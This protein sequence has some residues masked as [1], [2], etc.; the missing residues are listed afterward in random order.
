MAQI[1][2]NYPVLVIG[3]SGLDLISYSDQPVQQHVSNPA[4]IHASYGGVARNIAETLARLGQRANLI[5]VVGQDTIGK[6]LLDFTASAGVNTSACLIAPA[7]TATYLAVLDMDRKLQ[8]GLYDM[9]IIKQITIEYLDQH[10]ELFNQASLVFFDTNLQP[11]IIRHIFHLAHKAGIPVCADATSSDQAKRLKPYLG[12]LYLL[13]ANRFEAA[14]LCGR[15]TPIQSPE[16]GIETARCLINQGVSIAVLPMGEDGVCYA[17]SDTSGHIPAIRTPLL[18]P[19]GTGDALTATILFGLLNN[20]E[21]DEAVRLG[22]TAS[23]LTLRHSGA[24]I[25]DL[26]LEKLYNEL[27]S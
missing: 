9:N 22:V 25:P 16:S 26:T 10:K 8:F 7:N 14:I 12:R 19:T 13:A 2:F 17:N 1:N 11:N 21:L 15:E 23:S 6:Q 4:D 27:V 18:D 3:S 24:V 5:S 20:I